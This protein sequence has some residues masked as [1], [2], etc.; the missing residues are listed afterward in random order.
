MSK[1]TQKNAAPGTYMRAWQHSIRVK[2]IKRFLPFMAF[3]CLGLIVTTIIMS[4]SV[5]STHID[6]INSTITDGKLV[7]AEPKLDGFT[8]N[9]RPYRV[10]ADRAIQNLDEQATMIL[11]KLRADVEMADGEKALLISP[12][13]IYNNERGELK[14]E[15]ESLLTTS[16]GMRAVFGLADI[17]I[18]TGSVMASGNVLV[19]GK[20]TKI[21]ASNMRVSEGGKRII[22]D[23]SVRVV[24]Q[25]RTAAIPDAEDTSLAETAF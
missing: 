9:N 5:P 3:A 11:E 18:E 2:R 4:K 12:I 22:F 10:S 13:G 21:T 23:Q 24:V 17:D 19:S 1:L 8:Q 6:V 25:P 20:R 15:Q 14:L 16:S 7:M